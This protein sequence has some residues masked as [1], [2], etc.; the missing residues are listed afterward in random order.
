MLSKTKLEKD[1]GLL[2]PRHSS[3]T[4]CNIA[5][6]LCPNVRNTASILQKTN[7]NAATDRW[8]KKNIT[9]TT[10]HL[11]FTQAHTYDGRKNPTASPQAETQRWSFSLKSTGTAGCHCCPDRDRLFFS[12]TVHS[13]HAAHTSLNKCCLD[14]LCEPQL[15]LLLGLENKSSSTVG[16]R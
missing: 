8:G 1:K 9:K 15:K 6:V 5:I 11:T 16:L 13:R 3:E 14:S 10:A 2:P 12:P 4:P 7:K